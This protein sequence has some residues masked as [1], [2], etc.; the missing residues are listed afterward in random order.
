MYDI[1]E[2][3]NCGCIGDGQPAIRDIFSECICDC[4]DE[5]GSDL[6]RQPQKLLNPPIRVWFV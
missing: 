3:Q 4:V 2:T 1:I 6:P 5:C